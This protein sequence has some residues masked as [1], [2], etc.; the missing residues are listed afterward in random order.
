MFGTKWFVMD[1]FL[2]MHC[3]IFSPGPTQAVSIMSQLLEDQS[4][5]TAIM[6]A[7]SQEA[8]ADVQPQPQGHQIGSIYFDNCSGNFNMGRGGH[9]KESAAAEKA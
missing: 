5:L 4:N 9:L 1:I 7:M 6:K 8:L 2:I 3:S